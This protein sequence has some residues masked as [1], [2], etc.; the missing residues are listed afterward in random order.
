MIPFLDLKKIN[1]RFEADFKAEFTA[2]LKRGQLI[3]GDAVHQFENAFAQYCGTKHCIGVGNGLEALHL[4]L[5]GYKTLGR[6]QDGDQ[7]IV[8]SNTYIATILAIKQAGLSPLLMESD[9]ATYNFDLDQLA[10]VKGEKI[11]GIMPVHL[12]GQLAPME[13]INRLAKQRDWLVIEDAAQG[14]GATNPKGV[15]AGNLGHAAGFSFYPTKNLGALGDGGAVTT[16]DDALA[17]VVRSLR[18]Y[19]AKTKYINEHAG[20][21]SRLD[22]LQAAFLLKKLPILDRDNERRRVIAQRYFEGIDQPKIELQQQ[23][24]TPD[25]VYHLFVVRVVNRAHFEAYLTD[26]GVGYLIHYP[27]PPHRQKAL[28]ALGNLSFPVTE[29]IHDQIISLPISPVMTDSE[30]DQVIQI[31]N[32]Y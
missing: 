25:H 26:N 31:L 10:Q 23:P 6:L 22:E 4:I 24:C 9:S 16:N 11:R 27:V 18:N 3:L 7:I 32:R 28:R 19:G 12:Y 14:H 17:E 21:N 20:F 8:A 15:K 1:Q 30:V 5:Q 29:R 2:F 13:A